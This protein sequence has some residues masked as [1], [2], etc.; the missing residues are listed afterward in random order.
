[1][2]QYRT[3]LASILMLM[4]FAT[5]V[6]QAPEDEASIA[7]DLNTALT[8][9][10][11]NCDGISELEKSGNESYEVVCAEGGQYSISKTA[12]GLL[13]VLDTVTGLVFK[14][15]GK[16]YGAIPFTGQIYQMTD[17]VNE[18]SSEVARSLFSIIELSG[19]ECEAITAVDKKSTDDHIVSCTNKSK[20]HV[21]TKV[22]GMVAV[23]IVSNN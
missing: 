8:L 1:M 20:Y 16:I 18:H 22:D 11:I 15:I 23:D 21:Y 5:V 3:L 7:N 17:N 10:G 9:Q 14:G 2:K 13:S 12:N 6:A 4:L 19:K